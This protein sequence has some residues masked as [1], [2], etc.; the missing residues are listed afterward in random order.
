MPAVGQVT[1]PL[2]D[3][4]TVGCSRHVPEVRQHHVSSNESRKVLGGVEALRL[5]QKV[6]PIIETVAELCPT[7][8]QK[9][10]VNQLDQLDHTANASPVAH[11]SSTMGELHLAMA[12]FL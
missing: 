3:T 9:S 4:T 2:A 1:S 5:A 10:M 6:H 12:G 7:C 11:A 8:Y